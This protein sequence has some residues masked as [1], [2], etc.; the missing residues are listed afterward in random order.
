MEHTVV[1][2]T[3]LVCVVVV[4]TGLGVTVVKRQVVSVALIVTVVGI[5]FVVV[6]VVTKSTESVAY[7]VEQEVVNLPQ[8]CTHA[9]TVL[10]AN[11]N[12]GREASV[13]SDKS[14]MLDNERTAL[15]EAKEQLRLEDMED[16][17]SAYSP[18]FHIRL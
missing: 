8:V 17:L 10:A 11:E 18:P 1:V 2:T 12:A 16:E 13:T 7:S 9:V 15:E 6:T 5:V 3:V 4:V 14:I